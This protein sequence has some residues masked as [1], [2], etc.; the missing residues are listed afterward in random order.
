MN[1]LTATTTSGEKIY[2]NTAHIVHIQPHPW[3]VAIKTSQLG[4][5]FI[6]YPETIDRIADPGWIVESIKTP[7]TVTNY[8]YHAE[9]GEECNE[10]R[11]ILISSGAKIITIE[12]RR[13]PG[14][15]LAPDQLIKYTA[16]P[17]AYFAINKKLIA[18]EVSGTE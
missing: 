16:T 1:M 18:R 3:G 4:E 12:S 13:L 8:E 15:Y 2:I 6:V 11:D 9:D 17:A 14:G 10:I 5:T 7:P